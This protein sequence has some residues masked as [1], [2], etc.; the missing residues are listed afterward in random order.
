VTG[1]SNPSS[2]SVVIQRPGAVAVPAGRRNGRRARLDDGNALV[3]GSTALP[4]P[5]FID[6]AVQV[7]NL[8]LQRQFIAQ[9]S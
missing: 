9:T 4:N 1:G 3:R 2:R 7:R 5:R 8:R 6:R